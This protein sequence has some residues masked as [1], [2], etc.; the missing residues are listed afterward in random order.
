ME[1][2]VSYRIYTNLFQ[3]DMIP[4]IYSL[5]WKTIHI[6]LGVAWNV[7][8]YNIIR[9]LEHPNINPNLTKLSTIRKNPNRN[10]KVLITA[11]L[12]KYNLEK[13]IAAR[14]YKYNLAAIF[15]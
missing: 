8:P 9:F 7:G 2:S 3:Q 14:L 4:D 1:A 6:S 11:R 15:F 10:N 5:H 12:Y 13:N